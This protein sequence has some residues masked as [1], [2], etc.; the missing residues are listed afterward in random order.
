MTISE[1]FDLVADLKPDLSI[2]ARR[3]YTT[4]SRSL[5]RHFGDVPVATLTEIDLARYTRKLLDRRKANGVNHDL[6]VMKAVGSFAA[7]KKVLPP[8]NAF[9]TLDL[10]KVPVSQVRALSSD[11]FRRVYEAEKNERLKEIYLFAV[12]TG[13]RISNLISLRNRDVNLA[14]RTI[15]L[16]NTKSNKIQSIPIHPVIL[17]RLSRKTLEPPEGFLFGRLLSPEYVSR[18]FHAAALDAGVRGVKFHSLRK[19]FATWLLRSKVDIFTVSKLHGHSSIELTVKTY[20]SV[21][22]MD[23]QKDVD[24]LDVVTGSLGS[25]LPEAPSTTGSLP[26]T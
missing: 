26:R 22:G 1:L 4:V 12:M 14:S 17:E 8:D 16:V 20:A 6:R 25:G 21:V 15:T 24:K 11:E 9:V 18:R 10:L 3:S 2:D 13:I 5:I 19:T 7:R 23:F